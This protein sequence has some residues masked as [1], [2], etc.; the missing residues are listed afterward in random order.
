MPKRSVVFLFVCVVTFA[1]SP[2]WA[3]MDVAVSNM[4]GIE[5]NGTVGDITAYSLAST[6]CNIGDDVAIWIAQTNQHPVI[7]GNWV[8][9]NNVSGR[10]QVGYLPAQRR[11]DAV[12]AVQLR[13]EQSPE[14]EHL[15]RGG[16]ADEV[17]VVGHL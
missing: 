3:Q 7:A 14:I 6:S 9:K 11:P 17:G 15:Q 10:T 16:D 13:R 12:G 2:T 4:P 1:S 5:K 8:W